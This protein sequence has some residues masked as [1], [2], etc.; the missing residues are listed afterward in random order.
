[1]HTIP[2]RSSALLTSWS[3]L[4]GWAAAAPGRSAAL[5]GARHGLGNP[6]RTTPPGS[7]RAS[8]S[9]RKTDEWHPPAV[10]AAIAR[11][12]LPFIAAACIAFAAAAA[13]TCAP[14]ARATGCGASTAKEHAARFSGSGAACTASYRHGAPAAGVTRPPDGYALPPGTPLV[15]QAA[16]GYSVAQ[17]GK[18]MC[19]PGVR[20]GKL[21]SIRTCAQPSWPIR[22]LRLP[23]RGGQGPFAMAAV[24]RGTC[25]HVR[26][27]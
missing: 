13:G 4:A 23:L 27:Q 16:I 3:F 12:A 26:G 14:P 18:P 19:T 9:D 5:A 20:A 21:P 8:A 22:V 1:M 25:D 10:R 24:C 2:G 15:V 6:A 17:L 11:T 7:P